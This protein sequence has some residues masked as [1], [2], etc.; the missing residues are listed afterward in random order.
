MYMKYCTDFNDRTEEVLEDR[1]EKNTITS[2]LFKR[3][4]IEKQDELE[5]YLSLLTVG[6]EIEPLKWWKANEL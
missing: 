4:H 6:G 5:L 3:R 1:L 2:W